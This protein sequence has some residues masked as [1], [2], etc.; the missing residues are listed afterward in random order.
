M[1]AHCQPHKDRVKVTFECTVNE[2][3]YIKMLSAREHLTI[4]DFILSHIRPEFP[5]EPNEETK[6][7]LLDSRNKTDLKKAKS[8]TEFWEQ[9]G[10]EPHADN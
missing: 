3:A 7:A 5:C 6:Q 9:M 8:I 4:S 2:R 10:I 1:S